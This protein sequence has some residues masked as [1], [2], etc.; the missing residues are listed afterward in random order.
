MGYKVIKVEREY[1]NIGLNCVKLFYKHLTSLFDNVRP[2]NEHNVTGFPL[3]EFH[4]PCNLRGVFT[5]AGTLTPITTTLLMPGN[6]LKRS[7]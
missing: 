6:F 1:S 4:L 2:I 5:V 7:E 3:A